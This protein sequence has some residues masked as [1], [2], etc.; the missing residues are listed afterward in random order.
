MFAALAAA[1]TLAFRSNA[2]R[3]RHSLWLA[4]SIKFLIPFALLVSLGGQV[5]WRTG[6]PAPLSN[7]L[8]V[9][10]RHFSAPHVSFAAADTTPIP[11]AGIGGA[12]WVFGC[13]LVLSIRCRR[14]WRVRRAARAASPI[15][16]SDVPI[17]AMSTPE[18]MEP[19]VFGIWRPVLLLPEGIAARLTPEHLDAIIAHE[20][21][22]VRRRDNL[23]AAL[24]MA[25]ETLFWFHPLVWWIGARLVEE[26]ER[27]CDEEVVRAGK[28][29]EVYAESILKVCRYYLESP[30]ACVSGVTGSDL[31][32]RIEQIMERRAAGE[33]GF[34]RKALLAAAGFTAIAA[35]VAVG[36]VHAP[37]LRAQTEKRLTF[38][39]A[40]VK[41]NKSIR[42]PI[43]VEFSPSGR[44]SARG[45]P[46]LF[47]VAT[48][49][50]VPFQGP[51]MTWLDKDLAGDAYDVAATAEPGAIPAGASA[52]VREAAMKRMLQSLLEDRFKMKVRRETKEMPVY[53]VIVGKNGPKLT[54]AKIEEKDC[55]AGGEMF[56]VAQC[57]QFSGGMGRGLHAQ[58]VSIADVVMAVSN[59]ADRPVIDRT[60]LPGLYQIDTEGWTPMRPMGPGGNEDEGKQ[61]TDPT[62]P[63]L[64]MIFERLGLKMEPSKA[65]VEAIV[66]EHVEKPTE[67]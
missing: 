26:R 35:P 15:L 14:W 65:Q 31:K 51:R 2:A 43:G 18:M 40:S 32:K 59:W 41:P 11:W 12:V 19:G 5:R 7:A 53:A 10:G 33:L 49:Y 47:L 45:I 67:N 36:V 44:F 17:A 38:E 9:G 48:A 13:A 54:R 34:A 52:L 8:T 29:P 62:R 50:N 4:A 6:P 37:P 61:L 64:Y 25:V 66:V 16:L 63:T 57:H 24:H 58:A 55:P 20:L 56:N 27:A 30:V 21:C 23:T 60:G 22:H 46:L 39:V 28:E 3:L 1:M 42:E